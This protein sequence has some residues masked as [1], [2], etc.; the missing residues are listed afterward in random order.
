MVERDTVATAPAVRCARGTRGRWMRDMV[1]P[2][3]RTDVLPDGVRGLRNDMWT[4]Y[5]LQPDNS[6]P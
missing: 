6:A 3:S 2:D 1:V 5:Q 4:F